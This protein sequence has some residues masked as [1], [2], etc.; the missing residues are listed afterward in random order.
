MRPPKKK[1]LRQLRL[2]QKLRK[3]ELL[4]ASHRLLWNKNALLNALLI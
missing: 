2:L 1:K 3:R 4:H